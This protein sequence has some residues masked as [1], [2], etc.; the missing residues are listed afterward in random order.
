MMDQYP[1]HDEI[2]TRF[3]GFLREQFAQRFP[4]YGCFSSEEG[5][6]IATS[7]GEL[8]G[9]ELTE[10]FKATAEMVVDPDLDVTTKDHR[11]PVGFGALAAIANAE[12]FEVTQDT[13]EAAEDVFDAMGSALFEHMLNSG[14]DSGR[15]LGLMDTVAS[16]DAGALEDVL[17]GQVAR[18]LRGDADP[19]IVEALISRNSEQLGSE[20]ADRLLGQLT[21]LKTQADEAER[22][23]Q[24]RAAQA[25]AVAEAAREEA[26][27]Q[28]A[29]RKAAAKVLSEFSNNVLDQMGGNPDET[30]GW[31]LENMDPGLSD[32]E[33]NDALH[34]AAAEYLATHV[35]QNGTA[36]E[37]PYLEKAR[38]AVLDGIVKGKYW[39]LGGPKLGIFAL[40]AALPTPKD[41]QMFIDDNPSVLPHGIMHGFIGG[42]INIKEYWRNDV[43]DTLLF[44]RSREVFDAIPSK[45]ELWEDKPIGVRIDVERLGVPYAS[46]DD[47]M[48]DI[49]SYFAYD[50][51]AEG[52]KSRSRE[53][54]E[55]LAS[56]IK[57][58]REMVQSGSLDPS[59]VYTETLHVGGEWSDVGVIIRACRGTDGLNTYYFDINQDE[60]GSDFRGRQLDGFAAFVGKVVEYPKNPKIFL[61]YAVKSPEIE[62][63]EFSDGDER[64]RYV[65]AYSGGDIYRGKARKYAETTPCT[66]DK[67]LDPQ[68]GE[69]KKLW[70]VD[71]GFDPKQVIGRALTLLGAAAEYT[72]D[73]PHS[74]YPKTLVTPS[75][76]LIAG[77]LFDD[78]SLHY[79]LERGSGSGRITLLDPSAGDEERR[80]LIET[81]RL[82]LH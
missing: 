8:S 33:R 63:V 15:V 11:N 36:E 29:A 62:K 45:S 77:T 4:S 56:K 16:K 54:I 14:V 12:R 47:L 25:K 7:L 38:E 41:L 48:T 18:A 46:P 30:F 10:L 49:D 35:R 37:A 68:T 19:E 58:D 57:A 82:A 23:R 66:N 20:E 53:A 6:E 75:Q 60:Y 67:E 73:P 32:T 76:G 21:G 65:S 24:E 81:L 17:G 43:C 2:K 9:D 70:V 39:D 26:E 22:Q 74:L 51:L 72:Q 3:N 13:V 31:L 40:A 61:E 5:R 1:A 27:R 80:R 28:Q 64:Y 34:G 59:H 44:N 52:V 79:S 78:G 50:G 55:G 69:T 42:P 71:F